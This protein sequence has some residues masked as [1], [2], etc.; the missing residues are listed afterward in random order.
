MTPSSDGRYYHTVRSGETLSFI[1]GL[2]EINTAQ[3]MAWNGLG[4]DSLIYPDQTL[5]LMVTPPAP[6][7]STPV[8]ST[9]TAITVSTATPS[10]APSPT[11]VEAIPISTPIQVQET[12][13]FPE[14]LAYGAA[15]AFA[16]VILFVGALLRKKGSQD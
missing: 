14:G 13:D 1:A 2:Y 9:E 3:L 15:L 11:A 7:T 8:P 16:G 10:P 5:L 12:S 6:P 4:T